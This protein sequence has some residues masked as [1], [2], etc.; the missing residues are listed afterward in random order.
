MGFSEAP[1]VPGLALFSRIS[2]RAKA[3]AR[4]SAPFQYAG[5]TGYD[6]PPSQG[7]MNEAAGIS[8]CPQWCGSATARTG[9]ASG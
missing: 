9:G 8:E 2:R 5:L 4:S 1:G 3:H 7:R 6:A